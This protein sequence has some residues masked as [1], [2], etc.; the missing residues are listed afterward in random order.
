MRGFLLSVTAALVLSPRAAAGQNLT[1]GQR[2]RVHMRG[3]AE[4]PVIGTV[5][6]YDSTTLWVQRDSLRDSIPVSAIRAIER[7]AGAEKTPRAPVLLGIV[8]LGGLAAA[9]YAG[10]QSQGCNSTVEHVG[11]GA[12]GFLLGGYALGEV[13]EHMW[14]MAEGEKWATVLV[15]AVGL[16]RF[17][18]R[19]VGIAFSFSL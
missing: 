18:A 15:P 16:R 8:W 7:S 14:P 1:L 5:S 12:L 4:Q 11:C 6:R 2:V 13:I 17:N 10:S 19:R 3:R 9:T